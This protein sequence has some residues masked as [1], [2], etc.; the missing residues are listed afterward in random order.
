MNK[1]ILV[2]LIIFLLPVAL[3]WGLTRDKSFTTLPGIAYNGAEIIKFSSPMCYECQEL[4]K[5]FE[6]VYP[7]FSNEVALKKVDVT[8][9]DK[10]TKQMIKQYEV[11][12]VPTCIFKNKNGQEIRKTEGLIQPKIL[13]NYIEELING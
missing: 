7:N 10:A 1:N 2:I 3:Y 9:K 13:E 5:I 8:Q 12:L 4:E 11:K 6:E